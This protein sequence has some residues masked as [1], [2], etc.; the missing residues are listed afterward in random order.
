MG[1]SHCF[2]SGGAMEQKDR[3]CIWNDH[4]QGWA[5]QALITS[6]CVPSSQPNPAFLCSFLLEPQGGVGEPCIDG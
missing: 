6:K 3:A 1:K 4:R 2:D 5:L